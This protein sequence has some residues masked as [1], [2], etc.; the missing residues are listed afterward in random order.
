MGRLHP[1]NQ[2]G[3]DWHI[4]V[5]SQQLLLQLIAG[6]EPLSVTVPTRLVTRDSA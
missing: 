5:V 1:H 3:S 4:E 6:K 2:H